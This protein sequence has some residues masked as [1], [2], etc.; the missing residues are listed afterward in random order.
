MPP[1]VRNDLT[2][3]NYFGLHP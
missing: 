2:R 3:D 1:A